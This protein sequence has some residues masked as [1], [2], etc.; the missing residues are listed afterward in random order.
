MPANRGRWNVHWTKAGAIL[1]ERV[2]GKYWM[3]Y[4]A[5][6]AG[7]VR[8]DGRGLVG[9]PA[10]LD[11][12]PGRAHPGAPAGP[13][14]FAGGGARS[15]SGPHAGRDP[16]RL[17]RRRRS[18]RL[19]HGLGALRPAR[20]RRA[21]S[22]AVGHADLRARA[23][24]GDSSARCPTSCS[25]RASCARGRAGSST[26]ARPTRASG[27]RKR[28]HAEGVAMSN[29]CAGGERRGLRRRAVRGGGP[30]DR[31]P[32][33]GPRVHHRPAAASP[34]G[35]AAGRA[36]VLPRRVRAGEADGREGHGRAASS[37]HRTADRDL[38]LRGRR[39]AQ[40]QPGLGGAG[41]PRHPEPHDRGPRH[42]PFGGDAVGREGSGC[43]A[44]SSGWRC[45]TR[46]GRSSLRSPT[47]AIGRTST[48][49]EGA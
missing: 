20:T 17:Q 7:R 44:C 28:L 2:G 27:W 3:Y 47:I 21:S 5:R 8:P 41:H 46:S 22:P 29:L 4:M 49:R 6:S 11:G 31:A 34:A 26:T 18:P 36:L 16:A 24:L 38:A 10:A 43:M 35:A 32:D 30:G 12:G 39:P 13:L 48:C 33:G 14:R 40:G 37:A 42:R 15:A 1:D 23:S 25:S 45:P 9:G 19:P